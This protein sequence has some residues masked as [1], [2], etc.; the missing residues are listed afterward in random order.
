M[1]TQTLI[2]A[3]SFVSHAA[4]TKDIRDYLNGVLFEV[5]SQDSLTLVS[6]DG[7]RLAKCTITQEHAIDPGQY[8]VPIQF[9]KELIRD[10][11]PKARQTDTPISITWNDNQLHFSN[12]SRSASTACIDGKYP[13]YQRIIPTDEP[14]LGA[15][16]FNALFLEQA[17]KAAKVITADGYNAIRLIGRGLESSLIEIVNPISDIESAFVVV[18]PVK[19]S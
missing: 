5:E 10:F 9:V 18:M 17:G 3:L 19:L 15:I 6:C 7:H 2:P 8:I 11:K 12:A 14:V 13:D 1:I 4:A 16:G